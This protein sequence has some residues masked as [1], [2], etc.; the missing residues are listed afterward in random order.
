MQLHITDSAMSE[1]RSSRTWPCLGVLLE[2]CAL[3][4]SEGSVSVVK[5]KM[6]TLHCCCCWHWHCCCCCCYYYC[7]GYCC[8]CWCCCSCQ[9]R[10]YCRTFSGLAYQPHSGTLDKGPQAEASSTRCECGRIARP[11]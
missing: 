2:L 11:A 7:S 5:Q 8:C 1:H 6:V 10:S 3:R 9:R 4:T